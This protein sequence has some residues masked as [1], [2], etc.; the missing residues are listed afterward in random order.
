[1]D[2]IKNYGKCETTVEQLFDE[3]S[4]EAFRKISQESVDKNKDSHGY[5]WPVEKAN[6]KDNRNYKEADMLSIVAN[7][8]MIIALMEARA[9]A[10]KMA[11]YTCHKLGHFSD[12]CLGGSNFETP[13]EKQ[14]RKKGQFLS[15]VEEVKELARNNLKFIIEV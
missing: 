11:Y 12:T 9:Q 5:E 7:E 8:N 2:E 3:A 6:L 10:L 13:E 4:E 14:K 1:M 15:N